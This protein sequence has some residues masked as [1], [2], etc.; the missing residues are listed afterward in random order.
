MMWHIG[1]YLKWC[2]GGHRSKEGRETCPL[3][4]L[5]LFV[6]VAF[7]FSELIKKIHRYLIWHIL[8][9]PELSKQRSLGYPNQPCKILGSLDVAS[10]CH[11]C[12]PIR[13]CP[14]ARDLDE[15]VTLWT[16]LWRKEVKLLRNNSSRQQIGSS[17]SSPISVEQDAS[18]RRLLPFANLPLNHVT[19]KENP[20]PCENKIMKI[21]NV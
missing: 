18:T 4:N 12:K 6:V 15:L 19:G 17:L 21:I 7:F 16:I 20:V 11:A 8:Y 13:F 5:S 9:Y 2:W 10:R 3:R 1:E 14:T